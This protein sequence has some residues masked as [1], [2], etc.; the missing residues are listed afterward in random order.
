MV[1]NIKRYLS[2]LFVR[3]AR[4]FFLAIIL[5]FIISLLVGIF[6]FYRYSL[7]IPEKVITE[8]ESPVLFRDSLHK[9]ILERLDREEERFLDKR[10]YPNIFN[11]EDL[12]D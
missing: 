2:K 10:E 4:N 6:L 12:L 5:L 3:I 11:V 8:L 7:I 9:K 1:N